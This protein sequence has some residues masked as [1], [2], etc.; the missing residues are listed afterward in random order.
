MFDDYDSGSDEFDQFDEFDDEGVSSAYRPGKEGSNVIYEAEAERNE[1]REPDATC[2]CKSASACKTARCG[3]YKSGFVCKSDCACTKAGTCNNKMDDLS[4]IFG[5]DSADRPTRLTACLISKLMRENSK[6]ADGAR[7]WWESNAIGDKIWDDGR[8]R[9]VSE[10]YLWASKDDAAKGVNYASL[11]ADEQL[12]LKRR[13]LKHW[14]DD[15]SYYFYS[16][17][18]GS[19][20]QMDCTWHCTVCNECNDWREWHCKLCNKCTYG[21]SFPCTN[22][23]RKGIRAFHASEEEMTMM[24]TL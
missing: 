11:S 21:Q 23:S 18:R 19:L 4:Y 3:C 5:P 12:A 16:F 20:E 2:N 14:F 8:R 15:S 10:D 22:C 24:A 17:C 13:S 1:E 9:A 6:E 7:L